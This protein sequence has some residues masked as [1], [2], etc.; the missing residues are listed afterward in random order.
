MSR[1]YLNRQRIFLV[2][3]NF[4]LDLNDI[5]TFEFPESEGYENLDPN[6]DSNLNFFCKER[7]RSPG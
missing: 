6:W 2:F 4:T 1:S 3:P 5:L 7:A